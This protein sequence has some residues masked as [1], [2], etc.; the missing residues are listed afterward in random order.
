MFR[1]WVRDVWCLLRGSRFRICN[2]HNL[3][4]LNCNISY[5]A[6]LLCHGRLHS[7]NIIIN[8]PWLN[9]ESRCIGTRTY[10][11]YWPCLMSW[12]Q[13]VQQRNKKGRDKSFAYKVFPCV[14]FL[15]PKQYKKQFADYSLKFI[16]MRYLFIMIKTFSWICHWLKHD[17]PALVRMM[18]WQRIS[19]RPLSEP[20][21]ACL[22]DA[23]MRQS[24][25][26]Y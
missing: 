23:S 6:V 11:I 7:L 12:P 16:L 2:L 26:M 3:E 22:A 21:F 9:I 1:P 8:T 19:D 13:C 14:N 4:R 24:T 20:R 18:A 10:M 5:S 25:F 17:I 15:L